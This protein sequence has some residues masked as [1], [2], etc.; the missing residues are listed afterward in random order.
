PPLAQRSERS[1]VSRAHVERSAP[2]KLPGPDLGDAENRRSKCRCDGP[3]ALASA[4]P[5]RRGT[6]T[7]AAPLWILRSAQ[8]F[9]RPRQEKFGSNSGWRPPSSVAELFLTLA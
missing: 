4:R 3:A 8:N 7:A 6:L 2:R 9:K 1:E 5:R